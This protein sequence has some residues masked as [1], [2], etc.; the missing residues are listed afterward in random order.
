MVIVYDRKTRLTSSI[1][2]DTSLGKTNNMARE[3]TKRTTPMTPSRVKRHF[4]EA[5][6]VVKMST[7]S[8]DQLGVKSGWRPEN[9]MNEEKWLIEHNSR[10]ISR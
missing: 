10:S 2:L 9:K 7:C 6:L 4:L 8:R 1:F 5:I 3:A